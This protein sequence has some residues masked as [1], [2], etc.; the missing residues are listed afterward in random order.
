MQA[1]DLHTQE[2]VLLLHPRSGGCRGILRERKGHSRHRL[3]HRF[4]QSDARKEL[5]T[6]WNMIATTT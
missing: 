1:T 6:L 3:T 5:Y 4:H 2:A